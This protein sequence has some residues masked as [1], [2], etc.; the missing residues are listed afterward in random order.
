MPRLQ[1][2]LLIAL[3]TSAV[4]SSSIPDSTEVAPVKAIPSSAVGPEISH[5][6]WPL[7]IR[8][9]SGSALIRV[10]LS[11]RFIQKHA[12]FHLLFRDHAYHPN[13]KQDF[14]FHRDLLN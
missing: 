13:Y 7:I 8:R 10:S 5:D 1:L 9:L 14:R 3:K 11:E 4:L 12:I 2:L 6:L